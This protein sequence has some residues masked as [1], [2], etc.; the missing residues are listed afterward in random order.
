MRTIGEGLQAA[1]FIKK[2][3]KQR[4]D[5]THVVAAVA[6][7]SALECVRETLALALEELQQKLSIQQRPEFWDLIWE[8]Y[9]ENKLDYKTNEETLMPK[10]RQAGV[11]CWGLL[12]WLEPLEIEIRQGKQVGL[13]REVFGQQFVMEPSGQIEPVKMHA[14]GKRPLGTGQISNRY[15]GSKI[16]AVQ[17][18]RKVIREGA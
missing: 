15:T 1:G 16:R 6:R 2:R 10:R 13:L 11:D 4:L 7:L 9:V 12:R 5:S 14:T 17:N 3:E 18:A 8:R